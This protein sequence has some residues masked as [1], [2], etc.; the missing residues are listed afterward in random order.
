MYTLGINAAFHDS[1]A[2]ILKDGQ[3]LAATEDERFTH[4]KHGKRPVPF[5]TWELP[6]HAIDYCLKEGGI[7]LAQVDHVAYSYE[8]GLHEAA[9]DPR[10]VIEMPLQPGLAAS[11]A[12]ASPWDPLFLCHILNARGQLA[13]GAPHHL[14]TRF[15]GAADSSFKW[16]Y[17][18]HHMAHEAS[19][20]LASP[21]DEC[22]VLTMDGRGENA[23]T[24][25]GVF[26]ANAY[27]RIGQVDLPNSLGLLYE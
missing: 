19:A 25:Y 6:F 23:T 8:P 21:F 24:S 22:A 16:H 10:G 4:V 14:Q 27:E 2:C 12:N 15:R 20:F 11:V 7:T 1:A 5:S 26:R 17:V 9:E 3:L 13:D 18:E